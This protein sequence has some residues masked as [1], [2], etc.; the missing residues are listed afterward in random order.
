MRKGTLDC[1]QF[2]KRNAEGERQSER[3]EGLED[4][5]KSDQ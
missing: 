1:T 4:F 2:S 5:K 3:E